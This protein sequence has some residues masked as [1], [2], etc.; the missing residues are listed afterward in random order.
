M[1]FLKC[2]FVPA[3]S[4]FDCLRVTAVFLSEIVSIRLKGEFAC[5]TEYSNYCCKISERGLLLLMH[6]K[7]DSIPTH[8]RHKRRQFFF[9]KILVSS[10]FSLSLWMFWDC[11]GDSVMAQPFVTR[12]LMPWFVFPGSYEI[13]KLV[14]GHVTGRGAVATSFLNMLWFFVYIF[15]ACIGCH[16]EWGNQ[17]KNKVPLTSNRKLPFRFDGSRTGPQICKFT[18]ITFVQF[19]SMR[20]VLIFEEQPLS[21]AV[22]V[23]LM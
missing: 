12:E 10:S 8:Y 3:P 6:S 19:S 1:L 4:N 13:P 9:T 20:R 15:V 22:S 17:T 14:S 11:L 2:F 21:S 23:F 7:G 5:I 18:G 16:L